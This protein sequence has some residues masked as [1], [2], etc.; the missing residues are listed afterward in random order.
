MLANLAVF[1]KTN[2]TPYHFYDYDNEIVILITSFII[3]REAAFEEE[4]IKIECDREV[5][6][7][8]FRNAVSDSQEES[9]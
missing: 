8:C 9:L 4:G 3:Q 1:V 2:C 7:I 6:W 5:T